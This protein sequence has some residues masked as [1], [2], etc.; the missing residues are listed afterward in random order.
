MIIEE[1]IKQNS[2]TLVRK[3]VEMARSPLR[4]VE[5]NKGLDLRQQR[6]FNMAILTVD[7]KG[8]S[9]YG[10]EEYEA[11]FKDDS[12]KFYSEDVR[13]DVQALGSLGMQESNENEEV[14]RSVFLEVRYN[15]KSSTY[16]FIFSPLMMN[17]V[18]NVKKNYI[19]QDLQVLAHF[20]N[21]YSFIWYDFFKS[22]YRQWKWKLSKEELI[23]LLNLGDKKSYLRN[24]SMLMQHCIETPL[25]ELN[26]FTEYKII[27]EVVKKGRN[28]V[29]YEFKRFT[30]KEVELTVSSAQLNVLQEIVER[31]GDTQLIMLEIASFATVQAEAVTYLMN[32]FVEI[33]AFKVIL[34]NAESHTADA[35]KDY[36]AIAIKKDN[37]FKAKLRELYEIKKKN[38]MIIYDYIEET[39][40]SKPKSVFYNWLDESE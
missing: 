1:K 30:E 7:D 24:H 38:P 14:W 18:K 27:F 25:A 12:D 4:L 33:Q 16:R 28:V 13:K 8:I 22:N 2:D 5:L 40:D 9:E 11:I 10:K 29:G 34:A 19:Q 23:V 20:K 32:L 26:K 15:K 31:Y 37:A 35:F 6:F 21:K 17:H 36:V 39:D 3:S